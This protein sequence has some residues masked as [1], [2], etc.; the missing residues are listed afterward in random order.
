M[1]YNIARILQDF[2]GVDLDRV[3]LYVYKQLLRIDKEYFVHLFK[4]LPG[5][6]RRYILRS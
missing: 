2:I 5:S 6:L 3:H 4:V 1:V